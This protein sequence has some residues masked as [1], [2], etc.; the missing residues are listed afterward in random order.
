M[1]SQDVWAIEELVRMI[2]SHTL[3]YVVQN[4]WQD[5]QGHSGLV[6]DP[7]TRKT[8]GKCVIFLNRFIS[9]IAIQ[10][11]WRE[12]GSLKPLCALLPPDYCLKAKPDGSGPRRFFSPPL[13]KHVSCLYRCAHWIIS[14][15]G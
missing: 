15:Y 5:G 4:V 7:W 13:Q 3:E 14:D 6:I 11:L 10:V 2:C 1:F 9:R 8:L 12:P